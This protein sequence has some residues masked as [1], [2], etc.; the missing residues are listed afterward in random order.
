MKPKAAHGV[1][2]PDAALVLDSLPVPVLE[3]GP[4]NTILAA[5]M[6]AEEFFGMS[7]HQLQ[8]GG[9]AEVVAQDHPVYLLLEHVRTRGGS[10]TEHELLFSSPRFH[11]EGVSVQAA[12]VP[13]YPDIILLTFHEPAAARMLDQQLAY[14]SAARSVSGLA[15]MLAHEVRN[16]LSG[17]KGAAQ[18]LEQA[19]TEADRDLATLIC[20]EVDRID[21][22]V[23]RMGMFGEAQ[24][25]FRALNIHRI[26]EHVR[27]LASNGF[28][29]GIKIVERYDPSLP[30][31]WGDRDRLVQVLLNL[32]KN[33]AEAIRNTDKE[34]EITL[35]TSYRPGIRVAVPG[36]GQWRHLPLVVTVRDTGPGISETVRPHLFEPFVSTKINGSGL[37]LAL[38][39]KV[40]D[41]HGGVIEVES[42]PGC[43]EI[44]LF[45][46]IVDHMSHSG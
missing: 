37:G 35:L 36:T 25:D 31:V 27:L 11:H 13:D 24:L 38:V 17:I 26:L 46:P 18:L 40:M 7:R 19:V 3:I 8:H 34:G 44:S 15:A 12:D 20:D 9:L 4:Q 23:D 28:A 21:A 10:V 1:A 16:P 45:L 5:N 42:R 41:D 43:T 6:A 14:R 2:Q 32:V 30:H 29:K 39:G 33:A 22:L